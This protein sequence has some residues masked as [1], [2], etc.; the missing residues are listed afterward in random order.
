[1][2]TTIKY[3]YLDENHAERTETFAG[4]AA[5]ALTIGIETLDAEELAGGEYIYLDSAT[6][7]A[8]YVVTADAVAR[9][10]AAVMA[11]GVDRSYSVWCSGP[12]TGREA[13]PAEIESIA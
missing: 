7:H 3:S 8:Y 9:L 10:G 5:E 2:T 13:T 6:P 11:R 1:M 12:G 4:D